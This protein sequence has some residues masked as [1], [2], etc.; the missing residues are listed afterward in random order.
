MNKV[1][2][3]LSKS[4]PCLSSDL[5][6]ELINKYGYHPSTARK[7]VS[8]S[9]SSPNINRL[10]GLPFARNAKFIY[11]KKDYRSPFYW[12]AL[13]KA[14]QETN[15][16]YWFAIASLKE[17]Q[18][19]VPYE[20]FLISCGSP[21]QQQKHISPIKILERLEMHEI[22]V[23]KEIKGL[24]KC[25]VL[26]ESEQKEW[27]IPEIQSRIITEKILISATKN[28][29]KNI[30]MV[31]YNLLKDRDDDEL[32]IVSTTV[33]DIAGPS[34][35]SALIDDYSSDQSKIKP[36]FF[37]CDLLLGNKISEN[38]IDPFLKKC[39][40]LRSLR[41]VGRCMQMFIAD[42][43][44]VKAF[45]KAK[46]AGIMPTTVENLFGKDVAKGLKSLIETLSLAAQSIEIEPEKFNFLF[47]KLGKIEGAAGN[48]RGV[49]FEY[50]TAAIIPK[51]Y[52]TIQVKLNELCKT[53]K[54]TAESDI[55][56]ILNGEILFIE[57]KGH[58]LNGTVE[59]SEVKKWLQQR[60]PILREY[61]KN[62]PEWKHHRL[63]FELW[64]TGGFC[65]TSTDFLSN[66]KEEIKSYEI[67]YLDADRVRQTITP[68]ND[69]EMIKTYINCFYNHPLRKLTK[70]S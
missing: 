40:T 61:A 19:I 56:A 22:I 53:S 4:G 45:R 7:Q 8:R 25:V 67:N 58:Q 35:L 12:R 65:E 13:Y 5:T 6:K 43:Y 63:R 17:R 59:F 30:G 26:A 2:T 27:L 50:Y 55:I 15:S 48:L 52:P 23:L 1:E 10:N 37:A 44:H 46:E 66:A 60:V 70:N 24:G 33:W 38:G 57:C 21:L 34:Y 41:N 29:L 20:H 3:I 68:S 69:K 16:S 9:I 32:P 18:G 28:W 62:H 54:G 42:E 31:S 14:F 47:E 51:I 11:L 49:L 39:R 36:G 64:T